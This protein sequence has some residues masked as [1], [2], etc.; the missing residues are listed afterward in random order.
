MS[1]LPT[2]SDSTRGGARGRDNT[3]FYLIASMAD[4]TWRMF[5]PTIGLLL[6]G[7]ALDSQLSTKPWLMLLGALIGGLI[8][9]WLIR[10]QL[11]RVL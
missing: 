1:K 5:L 6:V 4:T 9:V 7:D 3:S 8:A 11:R 2:A 10:K